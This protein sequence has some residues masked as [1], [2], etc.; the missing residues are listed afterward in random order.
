MSSP[1]EGRQRSSRLVMAG[2][3][4]VAVAGAVVA[5]GLISRANGKQELVRWA[6]EQAV[7]TVALARLTRGD[8]EQK[9]ILPGTIQ[10][11]NKAAIY[12]RVNGYLKSWEQ[13]I[14]AHVTKGQLL[15]SI[16]TPDLDQQVAQAKAN[17]ASA[18]A[19]SKLASV[20][21]GRWLELPKGK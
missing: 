6:K 8:G 9:L 20:T 17:L 12:A 4:A 10:P 3:L 19:D 2:V 16:D 7:P 13:D 1:S 15:A 11:Y 21:A 5:N 18:A 14:G